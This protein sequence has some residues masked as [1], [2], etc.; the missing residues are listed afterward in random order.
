MCLIWEIVL[1]GSAKT[2]GDVSR[3]LLYP[4]YEPR[5]MSHRP[6]NNLFCVEI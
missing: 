1:H 5:E 4:F 3:G 2:Q 6:V